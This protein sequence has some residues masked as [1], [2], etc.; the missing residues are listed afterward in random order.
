MASLHKISKQEIEESLD[1]F[2]AFFNCNILDKDKFI[3]EL[4]TGNKNKVG[5]AATMIFYSKILFLNEPFANLDPT[6]RQG[7]SN[8]LIEMNRLR[9]TTM[10]I[11]SHDLNNVVAVCSPISILEDGK[12]D[13]DNQTPETTYE[14]LKRYFE[15]IIK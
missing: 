15:V 11:S 3:R 9:G 13:N 5:I 12:I 4:S 1:R 10:N 2:E 7:L 8:L 14:D 6:S